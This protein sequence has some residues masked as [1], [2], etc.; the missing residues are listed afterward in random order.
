M[1]LFTKTSKSLAVSRTSQQAGTALA[2]RL[3]LL[4]SQVWF[5]KSCAV[6]LEYFQLLS[7]DLVHLS[8]PTVVSVQTGVNPGHYMEG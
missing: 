5:G 7:P 3:H 1:N 4:P 8:T 2:G 6:Q